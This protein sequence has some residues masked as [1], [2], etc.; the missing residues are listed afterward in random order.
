MTL[1]LLRI[2]KIASFMAF[3][4]IPVFSIASEWHHLSTN[5]FR[6]IYQKQHQSL[7]PRIIVGAEV[8]LHSLKKI[9]HYQPTEIITIIIRDYRDIGSAKVTVFRTIR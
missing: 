6:F 4:L 9:F 2:L 8:S 5:N 3:L 1:T 7:L